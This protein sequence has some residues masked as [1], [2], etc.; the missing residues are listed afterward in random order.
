[1]ALDSDD[2]DVPL[3][4]RAGAQKRKAD[5]QPVPGQ[6]LKFNKKKTSGTIAADDTASEQRSARPEG[7]LDGLAVPAFNAPPLA[8][9]AKVLREV[10]VLEPSGWPFAGSRYNNCSI[11]LPANAEAGSE[12]YILDLP[13]FSVDKPW[14]AVGSIGLEALKELFG[15]L[16]DKFGRGKRYGTFE[17][18]PELPEGRIEL[19][20]N[21]RLMR[22]HKKATVVLFEKTVLFLAYRTV[23]QDIDVV[24]PATP[25]EETTLVLLAVS[26]EDAKLAGCDFGGALDYFGVSTSRTS[27]NVDLLKPLVLRNEAF[28]RWSDLPSLGLDG[29]SYFVFSTGDDDES[30][31]LINSLERL[32]AVKFDLSSNVDGPG[33][34][35]DFV[36]IAKRHTCTAI[37]AKR[38]LQWLKNS[39]TR[40]FEF[41]YANFGG[42]RG[43]FIREIWP[44]TAGVVAWTY[45]GL[46]DAGY[47][48]VAAV[49]KWIV[50][51]SWW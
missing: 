31:M 10:Q 24:L 25:A 16:Q 27:R 20:E 42:D 39:T 15:H 14:R 45:Q 11:L 5:A 23:A 38:L 50:S 19:P 48:G 41:D 9:P 47:D 33:P 28:L 4:K 32:N 8:S 2:E 3:N 44:R 40:F 34:K 6:R 17:M 13:E 26:R 22:D 49:M 35:L 29:K 1:M 43:K 51:V 12:R 7:F 18:R 37:A 46:L 21:I 36:F 30:Q